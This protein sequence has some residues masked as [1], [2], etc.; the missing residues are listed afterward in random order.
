MQSVLK[1]APVVTLYFVA[2][3]FI[4]RLMQL[5]IQH[6]LD[7][8]HRLKSMERRMRAQQRQFQRRR[9]LRRQVKTD[10]MLVL[11]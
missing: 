1:M 10:E 9:K 5:K 2:F 11:S 6:Y 8:Q 3:V 4:W 7:R